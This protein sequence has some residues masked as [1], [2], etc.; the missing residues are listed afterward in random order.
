MQLRMPIARVMYE[1]ANPD[2]FYCGTLLR[3]DD[4]CWDHHWNSE[5]GDLDLI[6][7]CPSCRQA[8]MLW[9][10]RNQDGTL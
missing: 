8:M 7:K 3:Y 5:I 9:D 4:V 1:C 2:C 6:A 10:E